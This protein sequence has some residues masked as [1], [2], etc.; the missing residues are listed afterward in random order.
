MV[1]LFHRA[2]IIK[3]KSCC[4][5]K[6]CTANDHSQVCCVSVIDSICNFIFTQTSQQGNI[7]QRHDDWDS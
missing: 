4:K 3:G 6:A 5:Q 7:V 1:S 2:T